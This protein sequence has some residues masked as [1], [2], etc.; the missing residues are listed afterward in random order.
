MAR[1]SRKKEHKF[2]KRV[3]LILFVILAITSI[4]V[5]SVRFINPPFTCVMFWRWIT[6][7]SPLLKDKITDHWKPLSQISPYLRKAVLAGEDQRFLLHNG[8]D[9]IELN[10]AI[11]DLFTKK[12]KRGASTITMQ[13]ARTVFLWPGRSWIRKCL[14][15]YYTV[16]IE[17][18]WPKRRILEVYL[19]TV[20]WGSGVRGAEAASRKYFHASC[21]NI[22]RDQ[23]A[24]LAAI[25]P[26]PHKWSPIRPNMQVILRKKR[27]LKDMKKMPLI[28]YNGKYHVPGPL[29]GQA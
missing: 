27:I 16:L 15:A 12:G 13:V 7:S 14:E 5:I 21:S 28:T 18:Y 17:L 26:S 10:Q 8:F 1:R 23:A 29:N 4:Q 24:I 11:H 9:L 25:L 20:D 3:F 19:N 6:D 2:T 22:S